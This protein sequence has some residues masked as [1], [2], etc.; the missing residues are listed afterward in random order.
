ME[1]KQDHNRDPGLIEDG[2]TSHQSS[3]ESEV[4]EENEDKFTQLLG[5]PTI[6]IETIYQSYKEKDVTVLNLMREHNNFVT[7]YEG[8]PE[9]LTMLTHG[10]IFDRNRVFKPNSWS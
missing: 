4:F 10:S 8:Y 2:L 3:I 9:F 5:L 1:L 6:S 7:V